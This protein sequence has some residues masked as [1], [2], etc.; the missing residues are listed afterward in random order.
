MGSG[1]DSMGSSKIALI[2]HSGAG[3]SF[4]LKQLGIDG[5]T[6]EMDAALGTEKSPRLDVAFRWLTEDSRDQPLVVV[7]NHEEMLIEMWKAKLAGLYAERFA[8]V[9]WVYLCKPKDQLA[10][11]LA[12][13]MPGGRSRD[14]PGVRYTLKNYDQFH[15]IFADLADHT[16]D[17]EARA[18]KRSQGN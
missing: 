3:K 14:L 4:C 12:K 7:S 10:Q 17:C 15:R 16:I 9:R 8:C 6:A 2:G 18:V 1:S 13:P 5:G 11:H